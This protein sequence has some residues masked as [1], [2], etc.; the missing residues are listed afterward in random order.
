MREFA[1]KNPAVVIVV[2]VLMILMAGRQLWANLFGTPKT[3]LPP[4][5]PAAQ[6]RMPGPMGGIMPRSPNAPPTL[7][8]D[9][10]AGQ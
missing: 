3:N 9:N 10:Q 2:A 7:S 8:G 6:G 4:N 1:Q 5:S